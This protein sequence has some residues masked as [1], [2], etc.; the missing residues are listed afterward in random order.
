MQIGSVQQVVDLIRE[1]VAE[2]V[3]VKQFGVD[4][5]SEMQNYLTTSERFYSLFVAIPEDSIMGL[6]EN[7]NTV[8]VKVFCH[9][10]IQPDRANVLNVV[11][12]TA[13]ILGDLYRDLDKIKSDTIELTGEVLVYSEN[14]SRLDYLAG[15]WTEL[16]F[17]VIP[18]TPCAVAKISEYGV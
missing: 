12:D 14:N 17:I 7:V 1:T 18:V 16:E 8:K 15:T 6:Q 5:E 11:S 13:L 9:G 10:K 3:T 4:F 2:Y